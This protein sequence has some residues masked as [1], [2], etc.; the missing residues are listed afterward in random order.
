MSL[1]V[2]QRKPKP[3]SHDQHWPSAMDTLRNIVF[4]HLWYAVPPSHR[5]VRAFRDAS[6]SYTYLVSDYF[7]PLALLRGIW[8]A[9]ASITGAVCLT[10]PIS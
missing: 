4:M 6:D 5:T 9:A 1:A 7:K 2:S 10:S 3:V 8:C